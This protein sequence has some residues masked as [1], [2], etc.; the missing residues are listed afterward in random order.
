M[1]TRGGMVV[2]RPEMGAAFSN[3]SLTVPGVCQC[4]GREHME[5]R[6][7]MVVDRPEKGAAFSDHS[8]KVPGVWLLV[9]GEPLGNPWGTE[10]EYL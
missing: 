5:T 8:L 4:V 2:D 1:E 6:G 9:V 10:G 7:G 3:H